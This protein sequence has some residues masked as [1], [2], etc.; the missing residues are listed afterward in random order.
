[1]ISK[2][3]LL[4]SFFNFRIEVHTLTVFLNYAGIE[5][6]LGKPETLE[7]IDFIKARKDIQIKKDS[8]ISIKPIS[9]SGSE[10]IIRFRKEMV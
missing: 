7:M 2:L 5:F 8:G 1:M 3:D 4:T 9:V 6:E 10:K